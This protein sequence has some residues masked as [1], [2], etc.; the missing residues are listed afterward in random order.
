MSTYNLP[1]SSREGIDRG[2]CVRV[3]KFISGKT[4]WDIFPWTS[5]HFFQSG[6][7]VAMMDKKLQERKIFLFDYQ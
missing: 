6:K 2:F 1:Q 3:F 7:F 4:M 5:E